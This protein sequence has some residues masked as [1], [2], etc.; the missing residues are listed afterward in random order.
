MAV[1]GM[2]FPGLLAETV[3]RKEAL[4]L[5]SSF[6][7]AA[8]GQILA[9]PKYVN[10]GKRLTTDRLFTPFYIFNHS[11]GGFIIISAENKTYPILAYSLK[12]RFD[13]KR[14]SDRL[15]ALLKSYAFDI[16][17]IRYDSGI[18]HEAILAWG[19]YP[20]HVVRLLESPKIMTSEV[21]PVNDSIFRSKLKGIL[22]S[23]ESER[24]SSSLFSPDQ[25]TE[26]VKKEI[27]EKGEIALGIPYDGSFETIVA[28]GFRD[29]YIRMTFP[30][31]DDSYFRLNA[32]EILSGNMFA[33]FDEPVAAAKVVETEEPFSFYENFLR[34]VSEEKESRRRSFERNQYPDEPRIGFLGSGH[35]NLFVPEN[36]TT[37]SVFNLMGA[38]VAFYKFK[39]TFNAN[40]DISVQPNGFYFAQV[41]G[42][43][44][45]K[46]GFK[47]VR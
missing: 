39:D 24:Y 5:A 9:A 1:L 35:F 41:V 2:F 20:V 40:I 4:K 25:W 14:L 36:I 47:L 37:V 18:P 31:M 7:N 15:K 13:E 29:D 42:E 16:E 12:D 33:A 32:S 21:R 19:N 17:N 34:E 28:N 22:S 27:A 3:S 8:N 23:Y 30:G 44:G 11:K 43:S 10:Y 45:R 38:K 6:F 26:I 46:Y